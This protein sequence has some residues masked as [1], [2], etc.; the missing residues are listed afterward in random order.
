MTKDLSE[1]RPSSSTSPS[2]ET[3][4]STLRSFAVVQVPILDVPVSKSFVRGKYT[5]V[6]YVEEVVDGSGQKT[7]RW[8]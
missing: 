8:R 2:P 4:T 5:S 1:A 3:D 6:E 7:V